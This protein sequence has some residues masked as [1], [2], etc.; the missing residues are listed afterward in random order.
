MGNRFRSVRGVSVEL[1]F[2]RRLSSCLRYTKFG[3]LRGFKD[4]RRRTFGS[5]SR[6]RVCIL[7]FG[8]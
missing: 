7:S 6:G 1:F 8:G 4:F 2:P 5:G 3:I